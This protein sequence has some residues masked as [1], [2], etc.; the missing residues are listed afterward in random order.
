MQYK[1][2][3]YPNI[4]FI[5]WNNQNPIQMTQI[6]RD[7]LRPMLLDEIVMK[8]IDVPVEDGRNIL[9]KWSKNQDKQIY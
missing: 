4:E 7:E 5:V 6:N 1:K 3:M 8:H 2:Q 9:W